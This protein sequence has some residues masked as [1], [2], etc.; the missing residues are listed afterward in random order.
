MT[1]EESIELGRL[2]DYIGFRMRRVQNHL[3]KAFEAAT[4]EYNLRTGLFSALALISA[5]PGISQ[6]QICKITNLDKSSAVQII[7]IL[8]EKGHAVRKP[9][10]I[11]RRRHALYTTP[12]GEEFLDL[13]FARL[14]ETEATALAQL[15]ESELNLLKAL[16]DRI[17][18][19]L[20]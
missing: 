10:K 3:V 7:D 1:R 9:S 16:L 20:K 15:S 4:T 18:T 14:K 17:F 11:D 2:G 12:A 5:N 19:V 13:L 8:E 6:N